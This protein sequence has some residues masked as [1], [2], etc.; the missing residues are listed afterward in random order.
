MAAS[1]NFWHSPSIEPKRQFRWFLE[2]GTELIPQWIVKSADKPSFSVSEASHRYFNYVFYY[3]G[4]VEWDEFK[5]TLV[6]PVTPNAS[7]NLMAIL[8]NMGYL[9][10]QLF[11]AD[12]NN[13]VFDGNFSMISKAKSI[14]SGLG[15][16]V[17]LIQLDQEGAT[18]EVWTLHNPWI[19]NVNFGGLDYESDDIINLELTIRYDNA[20][21]EGKI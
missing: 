12:F 13:Q 9:D 17:K 3:P 6:D 2:F 10:P 8:K 21:V 11:N 20:T 16:G 1:N 5:V 4:R 19:K 7:A 18:S 15:G 14:T